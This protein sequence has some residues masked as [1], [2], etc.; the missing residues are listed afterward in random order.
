MRNNLF[1]YGTLMAPEVV[2]TLLGRLPPNQPATLQGYRRHPVLQQVYPGLVE[3]SNDNC[4]RGILFCDL[5]PSDW[6]RLDRFEDK[7]Y[8]RVQVKV[9]A[10]KN[11]LT[12]TQTYLWTDP[13]TKLDTSLD[14]DLQVFLKKHLD[15]YLVRTVRPCRV[16]L[17][18]LQL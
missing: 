9:Q 17:D 6:Q 3:A 15:D 7:E 5:Q 11:D 14:W 8:T 16:E 12:D 13:L 4:V 1:V 10:Q 18:R 2:E